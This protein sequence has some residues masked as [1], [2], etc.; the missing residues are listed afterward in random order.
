MRNPWI[1]IFVVAGILAAAILAATRLDFVVL[2]LREDMTEFGTLLTT[3]VVAAG[4]QERALD[5][6]LSLLFG[7]RA[8]ELDQK[9]KS[10]KSDLEVARQSTPVDA[11]R[12]AALEQELKDLAEQRSANRT[13]TM[14][15][16]LPLGFAIGVLMSAVG[17]RAL[18]AL[19]A[20]DSVD[21][22]IGAQATAFAAID[23]TL[24][25]LMIAGGSDMLHRF[26][27]VFR[28]WADEKRTT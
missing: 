23:I 28:S 15:W 19:A 21:G 5:V 20:A 17:L 26:V 11:A 16:A 2:E 9:I 14:H 7:A 12:I 18:H 4:I 8:D 27:T 1:R 10:V 13:R 25:A 22:L 24:T 3:L 6:V